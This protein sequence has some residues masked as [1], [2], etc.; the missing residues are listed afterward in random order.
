MKEQLALIHE[1]LRRVQ[2]DG[3]AK[4][5]Q[6]TSDTAQTKAKKA[7][8]SRVRTELSPRPQATQDQAKPCQTSSSLQS[9]AS[10]TS[11]SV[12][13]DSPQ[14]PRTAADV[15]KAHIPRGHSVDQDGFMSKDIRR[16]KRQ[17]HR[18]M[19]TGT[20][21]QVK[22]RPAVND[23]R[24]FA[25]KLSPEETEADIRNYVEEIIGDRCNIEKI[26]TR[27]TRYASFIIT[28]SKRHE[29]L[30]LDPNSWEEGVQVRHFYGRL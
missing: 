22:L 12:T 16:N 7:K 30:L 18:P 9:H 23:V 13:A 29:T 10:P 21:T 28:A 2:D 24:I 25:T 17:N 15:L 5:P 27:T 3:R 8:Q 26:R 19:V 11:P 1:Q 6:S 4:Q 14:T 20:K